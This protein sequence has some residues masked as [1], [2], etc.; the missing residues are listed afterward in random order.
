MHMGHKNAGYLANLDLTSQNLVLRPLATV[1]Q[2]NFGS[3]RQPDR[4]TGNV[5][6]SRGYP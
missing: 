6:R 4:N 3:L 1:K 5:A 2:P